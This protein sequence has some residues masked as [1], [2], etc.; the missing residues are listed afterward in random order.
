VLANF[1]EDASYNIFFTTL[2]FESLLTSAVIMHAYG[3]KIRISDG[4]QKKFIM[5]LSI[6]LP[7]SK[8]VENNCCIFFKL[9]NTF[10]GKN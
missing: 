2:L 9:S 5:E 1:T 4:L 7:N 6:C 3:I 8:V 10:I